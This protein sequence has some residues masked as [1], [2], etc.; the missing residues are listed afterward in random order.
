MHWFGDDTNVCDSDKDDLDE[1]SEEGFSTID[2]R[3]NKIKLRRARERKEER[4]ANTAR[5][6]CNMISLGPISSEDITDHMKEN[7]DIDYEVAKDMAVKTHLKRYYKYNSEELEVLSIRETMA[8][9][10]GE[11]MIHVAVEDHDDIRDMF[12]R[13]ADCKRDD[14]ILRNFVPPQFLH[15]FKLSI[16]FVLTNV[17][18]MTS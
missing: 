8:S 11:G 16:G 15:A 10:K 3:R 1:D 13:K 6:A 14:T 17:K 4:V 2:R 7:R 18:K 9:N 5:K 12:A